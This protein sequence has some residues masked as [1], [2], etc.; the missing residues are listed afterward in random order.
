M[1]DKTPCNLMTLF[2]NDIF[3]KFGIHF[4]FKRETLKAI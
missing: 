4:R 2:S 3:Y 1:F